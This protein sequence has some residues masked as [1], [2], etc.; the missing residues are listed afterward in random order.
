MSELWV[1]PL[2]AG[3]A[4]AAGLLLAVK[5]LNGA[6]ASLRDSMRPLRVQRTTDRLRRSGDRSL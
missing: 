4:G 6:A 2:A 5:H 3:A 1:L